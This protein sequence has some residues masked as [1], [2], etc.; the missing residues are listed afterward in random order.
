M[1]KRDGI[2]K[3]LKDKMRLEQST[4]GWQANALKR[5]E[6]REVK[7]RF[8][9]PKKYGNDLRIRAAAP[10]RRMIQEAAKKRNITIAAYI[11]RS[12]AAFVAYDLGVTAQE[13]LAE[14]PGAADWGDVGLRAEGPED[15]VT[16][17][18]PWRIEP[19]D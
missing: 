16:G 11:R 19:H 5:L 8:S 10:L 3:D 18:G 6:E 4:E 2:R 7:H 17:Y 13:V 15:G 9:G 1:P 12:I 14:G